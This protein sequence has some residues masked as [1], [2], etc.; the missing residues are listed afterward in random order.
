MC[1]RSF[2]LYSADCAVWFTQQKGLIADFRKYATLIFLHICSF[3]VERV[4][5]SR[6]WVSTSLRICPRLSTPHIWSTKLSRGYTS[7]SVW[8]LPFPSSPP[9]TRGL[10]SQPHHF[11]VWQLLC[12]FKKTLMC[13]ENGWK[14]HQGL[15]TLSFFWRHA[16]KSTHCERCLCTNNCV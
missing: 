14:G 2:A 13:G 15:T 8:E 3:L 16:E 10:L 11:L 4:N 1:T 7:F 6:F 12:E 5:N 9:F